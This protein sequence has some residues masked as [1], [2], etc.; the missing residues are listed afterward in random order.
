LLLALAFAPFTY[1]AASYKVIQNFSCGADS[2]CYPSGPLVFDK[3]GNLY[4]TAEQGGIE[5]YGTIFQLVPNPD[6]T[7]SQTVLHS[8][9][10]ANDGEYPRFGVILD[11]TGN[12]YG[13]TSSAGGPRDLGTVFELLPDNGGWTIVLPFDGSSGGGVV[14]DRNGNIY[15]AI[16][17]GNYKAGAVGEL[18][19]DG[20]G[21]SYVALYSFCAQA[22]C[23]DGDTPAS[24]LTF[25]VAGNLYG[26]TEYGGN[27][28][29]CTADTIGCGVAFQLSPNRG[30]TWT[31][32]LMHAFAAFSGDGQTPSGPLVMDRNGSVYGTT[33]NGGPTGGGT[34]FK[35]I[36]STLG[37][38]WKE[39]VLYTF[40]HCSSGCSPL[41]GLAIDQA[42]NLYGAAGGGDM[43]CLGGSYCGVLFELSPQKGNQWTYTL[44]H[45]FNG[46][47]GWGSDTPT[48]GP[49]GNIYGVTLYGGQNSQGVVFQ[50][51][52]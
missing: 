44:V 47:D 8:F 32:H 2:S 52:P 48:I 9:D 30:G 26:T 7:W 25:D 51:T 15:G 23:A 20:N 3:S 12:L 24:P 39:T 40:P 18:S 19:P 16:G 6:D 27:K 28:Q 36:P 41:H 5:N 37:R 31:F 10:F 46:T 38:S 22:N 13:T 33:L 50:I 35:L 45:K 29:L 11:S 49:D 34:V 1:A 4:G 42:G 17:P 21:W 14:T 43:L